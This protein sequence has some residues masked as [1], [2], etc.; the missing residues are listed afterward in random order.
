M[1]SESVALL[2][3]EAQTWLS[4]SV[5]REKGSPA[6]KLAWREGIWP[7]PAC[8]T[9]PKTECWI[10]PSSTPERS[11]ASLIAVPPSSGA[12]RGASAPPNRPKG[13]RAAPRIT[14]RSTCEPPTLETT[15]LRVYKKRR[16]GG[17]PLV[18][19]AQGS[20][21][22]ER[23]EEASWRTSAITRART[24][25]SIGRRQRDSTSGGTWWTGGRRT[26]RP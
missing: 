20:F 21:A 6:W 22:G 7:T 10:S 11:I 5:V 25:A 26:V 8:T 16:S 23:G 24:P 3:P 17:G 1:V 2:R 13:V 14:A 12:D 18:E 9:I 4:V 19:W 15:T